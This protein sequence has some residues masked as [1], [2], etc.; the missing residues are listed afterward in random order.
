MAPAAIEVGDHTTHVLLVAYPTQGHINPLLQFGKR[1]A[2]RRGV[3]S[4]LAVTRFVLATAAPSSPGGSVHLAAI[5]DGCDHAGYDEAGDARAYLAR[6]ET[7]GSRTLAELLCAEAARGRPVHVVVY[8]SFL[9]WARGVARR[10]GAAC[11]AF[12]TQACAVNIAYGHAWSGTVKLPVR[13]APGELPGLPAGLEAGDLPTF[14]V[15]PAD[16]HGYQDMLVKQQFDGIGDADDVLVNSFSDLEP[17]EAE[18]LASTWG[19]KTIGPT[20]PSAYLDTRIP[21]DTSYGCHLHSPSPATTAWLD[22]HPARSVVYAAFGSV[23][24]ASPEQ[25]A[26][27]AEGLLATGRPFLW[28]VRA[29][30]AAKIPGD[31]AV[32]LAAAG[33]R[34]RGL[35]V[36]WSPQLE[37]LAHPAVGCFVTHCGWNSTTEAISAGVP[38]VA[39]PR[40][41]DQTM[42]AKYIADI[43]RVGVRA[44]RSGG[45][46]VVDG[47]VERG[48]VER[49]VREVM[50]REE[51]RRNAGKWREMAK[52]AVSEGGSS[53]A[54]IAAFVA[55]YGATAK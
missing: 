9:P 25:M 2:A 4:T 22:A 31:F 28:V 37:V 19:A 15:N 24:K 50:E 18:H 54:N 16:G 39:V 30:E 6:L 40:W 32:K 45:G 36:P 33:G 47:L 7:A 21:D 26:E 10:H 12:L 52:D 13:E 34:G 20:V 1:L 23:A 41:S 55:K 27:V 29:S 53:D 42:N 35:V 5:S 14:M 38:M 51:Y 17:P 8:D 43:W 11:A 49:C 46:G 48:E 44:R 3:R